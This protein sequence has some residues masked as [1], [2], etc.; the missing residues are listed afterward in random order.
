MINVKK[1][2]YAK[3]S[4]LSE[5]VTDSYPEDWETFPC[6]QYLEEENRPAE[7]TDDCERMSYVRYK[8]DIWSKA[9][10]TDTALLVNEIMSNLG[11]RRTTSVDVP[12]IN[13]LKHKT[14]RFEGIVDEK[15]MIVYQNKND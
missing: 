3:L 9:S 7:V 14:M 8:I 11:L 12:E 6:I 4:L 5:N 13:H 15:T 1:E 10:T 2:I